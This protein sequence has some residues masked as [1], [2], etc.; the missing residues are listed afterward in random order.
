MTTSRQLFRLSL[1]AFAVAWFVPVIKD[2]V[3]LSGGHVPGWDALVFSLSPLWDRH[4]AR[5]VIVAAVMVLSGS[6][7]A[8]YLGVM[9]R[10]L[11]SSAVTPPAVRWSL[12]CAAVLNSCWLMIFGLQR[13]LRVGYYLW[14]ASFVLLAWGAFVRHGPTRAGSAGAKHGHSAPA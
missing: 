9:M 12:V 14:W 10:Y 4:V 11:R 3:P 1:G 8:L 13:E 2:G 6:T 7:N 5:N